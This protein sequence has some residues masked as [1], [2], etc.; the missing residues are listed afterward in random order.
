MLSVPTRNF[1]RD[2]RIGFVF[3]QVLAKRKGGNGTGA[4]TRNRTQDLLITNQ[5]LYQLSYAGTAM[6]RI[7]SLNQGK[8]GFFY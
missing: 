4:G 6:G 5:L 1:S 7:I 8:C 2:R 3:F